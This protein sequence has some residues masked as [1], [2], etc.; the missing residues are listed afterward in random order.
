[1]TKR[2]VACILCLIL[3]CGLGLSGCGTPETPDVPET[4]GDTEKQ[5][6]EQ[7]ES[8]ETAPEEEKLAADYERVVLIGIDGAG[9]YFR[10]TETP[11]MD[12][13]FENGAVTYEA[14]TAYP[15]ISA[16]NWATVF[17]GVLPGFHGQTN[18][19]VGTPYDENSPYPTIFRVIRENDPEAVLASFSGW[20]AIN[21]G[22][23]EN[24]LDVYKTTG[25]DEELPGKVREYIQ[26]NDPKLLF[27]HFNEVDAAG[28]NLGFGYEECLKQLTLTDG[29]VSQI[30]D[31]Y[32][33]RGWL[34]STLFLVTADHGGFRTTHGGVTDE[35][36]YVMYAAVGH[37]VEKGTI[38][39]MDLRD[40]AAVVLYALGYEPYDTCTARVP[41]GLFRGVTAEERPVYN[42]TLAHR[43]HQTEPTPAI[44]S[45][46]AI[47]DVLGA[48][49]ILTYLPM[50]GSIEDAMGKT[51]TVQGGELTY[52]DGYFGSGIY[53]EKG[54]LALENYT[55]GTDSFSISLW[56]KTRGIGERG[57]TVLL[58]NKHRD[59][60]TT[61]GYR[62]RWAENPQFTDGD[63][64]FNA[65]NGAAASMDETY[66]LPAEYPE[67]WV[68]LLLVVDREAE[69]IRFAYD[70]EEFKVT[71]I[72]E[73]MHGAS[74]DGE[75]CLYIGQD[76]I[77][78]GS[79]LTVL[80]DEFVLID[81]AVTDA[82]KEAIK[83][84]YVS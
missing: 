35:E 72:P 29:Y 70:F 12:R 68:H 67:G 84:H 56:L 50:D 19:S 2:I 71:K 30:Y 44:G 10:N 17:T 13:I 59:S 37:T 16:E 31:A 41:S 38:Q 6:E 21:V 57:S 36:K 52:E 20:D 61:S 73:S 62:L 43:T 53:F 8:E 5:T 46:E 77:G 9:T 66:I 32:A 25:A 39:E 34:D 65:G 48:D 18:G 11:N 23:I 76:Y 80:L 26:E 42:Y 15:T 78:K 45:G 3:V 81:G 58:A 22:L 64:L 7:T 75:P 79:P 49:R 83:N 55:P 4:P 51:T 69:E 82:E 1:M 33:E 24:N 54:H 47:T 40:N 14:L 27:V 60:A 74:F 28:H 63:L